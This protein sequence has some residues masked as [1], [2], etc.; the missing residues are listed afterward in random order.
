MK[1]VSLLIKPSSSLCNMRCKYCFYADEVA[2]RNI[3]CYGKMSEAV[4]ETLVKRA[5]E[6][7]E[8]S[9]TFS[10]QGGEPTL[11]G[12]DFY[13]SLISFQKKYAKRELVVQNC[14]QTNG[15]II[16]DEWAKF[17]AENRFLVG[18]SMDGT[19][20]IHDSLRKDSNGFGSYEKV[21]NAVRCFQKYGV[22][23][24]VL[25]VVTKQVALC[26]EEVYDELKK[27]GYI[28]F[29]PCLDGLDGEKRDYSLTPTLYGKFLV[30]VF[31]RYYADFMNARPVSV[32]NFD[33]YVSMILGHQPENCAMRGVCTPSFTIEGDGSVYPC[34]FYVLDEWKMGNVR[35]NSLEEML[36]SEVA[37]RFVQESKNRDENCLKCKYFCLCRGGCKREWIENKPLKTAHCKAYYEFFDA[38][39]DKMIYMAKQIQALRSRR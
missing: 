25:C 8:N 23:F 16:D 4:L 2:N 39:I 18:L 21:Q 14:L 9:V 34:D 31:E 13:K 29:I 28:Q 38:S 24:N 11:V 37:K 20:E 6:S 36:E 12:L 22:E 35:E 10:F 32:R 3:K 19:K 15:Y 26:A 27:Y 17:L 33:N 1:N 7:A 30:K 5:F